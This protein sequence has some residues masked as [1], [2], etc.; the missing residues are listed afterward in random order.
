MRLMVICNVAKYE[1]EL[2]SRAD[3]VISVYFCRKLRFSSWLITRNV[4]AAWFWDWLIKDSLV[5]FLIM[6]LLFLRLSVSGGFL[7]KG[8]L[9][10]IM[11][12]NFIRY[13]FSSAN[14]LF[15]IIASA[16]LDTQQRQHRDLGL[17][18]HKFKFVFFTRWK[19]CNNGSYGSVE[20]QRA[21]ANLMYMRCVCVSIMFEICKFCVTQTI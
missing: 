13:T 3:T 21:R 1:Y 10:Q 2:L 5:V 14:T 6:I 4:F 19:L 7:S 15:I 8:Q 9:F 17:R 20:L 12:D 16:H 11:F 18:S